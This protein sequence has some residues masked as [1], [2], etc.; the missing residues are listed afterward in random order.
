MAADPR[1][2]RALNPR[3]FTRLT[4]L[5]AGRLAFDAATIDPGASPA[6]GA[7]V[8]GVPARGPSTELWNTDPE[9]LN[10]YGHSCVQGLP[11]RTCRRA[12]G[13]PRPQSRRTTWYGSAA[14]FVPGAAF[15]TSPGGLVAPV[16]LSLSSP[17]CPPA[18]PH[19]TRARPPSP[20]RRPTATTRSRLL[21]KARPFPNSTKRPWHVFQAKNGDYWFGKRDRG[22]YRYDGKTLITLH[23][24]RRV[25]E[26]SES[27]AFR[28][29]NR[30]HL[31]QHERR[32]QQ[33][34]RT[35]LHDARSVS[36]DSAG[37]W[38]NAAGRSVVRGCSGFRRGLP[39]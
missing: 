35:C 15:S 26:Q 13:C 5:G 11:G 37:E 18:S 12:K 21:P 8:S 10:R 36:T 3:G 4:S 14:I 24:E 29:T 7:G 19:R 25:A 33:I 28:K 17:R 32:H 16:S 6:A 20:N 39:L 31:L 22:A 9:G 30:E 34:R 27:A 1:S 38:K 2:E 23:D